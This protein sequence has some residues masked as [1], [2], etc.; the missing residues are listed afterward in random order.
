[1]N[2]SVDAVP[3]QSLESGRQ[4]L[5]GVTVYLKVPSSQDSRSC[6]YLVPQ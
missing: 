5:A 3:P 1:M 6:D 2:L 4:E